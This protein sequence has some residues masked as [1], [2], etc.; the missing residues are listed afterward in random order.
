MDAVRGRNMHDTKRASIAMVCGSRRQGISQLDNEACDPLQD[1]EVLNVHVILAY[2][3][4]N[5]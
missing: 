4:L 5:S 3:N 2:S 1:V